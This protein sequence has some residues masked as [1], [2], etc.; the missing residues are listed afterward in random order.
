MVTLQVTRMPVSHLLSGSSAGWL[1]FVV[2][3]SEDAAK[4]PIND[5]WAIWSR[6][7]EWDRGEWQKKALK[8][9]QKMDEY[10]RNRPL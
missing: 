6:L 1:L 10:E 7:S 4:T 8:F 3:A 5:T 9:I 2:C